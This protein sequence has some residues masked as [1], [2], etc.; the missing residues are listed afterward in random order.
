M[1][2]IKQMD[3]RQSVSWFALGTVLGGPIATGR[4]ALLTEPTWMG[5]IGFVVLSFLFT[6]R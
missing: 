2:K 4:E 1:Q 6:T 5:A 3:I